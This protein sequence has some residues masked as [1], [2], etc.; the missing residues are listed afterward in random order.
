MFLTHLSR[1]IKKSYFLTPALR[2]LLW[3]LVCLNSKC[4]HASSDVGDALLDAGIAL[5]G[6]PMG[7]PMGLPWDVPWDVPWELPWGL[8]ESHG[9][10]KGTSHGTSHGTYLGRTKSSRV[11]IAEGRRF[12]KHVTAS[13]SQTCAW[14][15]HISQHAQN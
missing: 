14:R 15:M 3:V 10:S 7:R 2:S 12:H 8:W 4:R 11:W 9:A 6:T 13:A 1:N 5:H